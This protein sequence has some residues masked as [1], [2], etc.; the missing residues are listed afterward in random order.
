MI[1][2]ETLKKKLVGTKLEAW[3]PTLGSDVK[4]ALAEKRNGDMHKWR[5]ALNQISN[6]LATPMTLEDGVITIG[7]EVSLPT[8]RRKSLESALR[9]LLPWRKGPFFVHGIHIDTEW[10][11]DF[12]WNRIKNHIHPLEGQTVLDVGCGN[13]YHCWIMALEGA[14]FAIGIDPVVK[15]IMQY[16]AINSF[17]E[18]ATAFVLPLR[19]EQVPRNLC[20]FDTV[21]SMGLLHHRK[22]PL[23]HIMNL[24]DC[25]VPNGQLVLETLVIEG[26]NGQVLV[27]EGRYAKMRNVWFL[28]TPETLASWIRRC[29]FID[30]QIVDVTL[31]TLEEQCSTDWMAEESLFHFLDPRD[32]T[33]TVEG[34]PAPIRATLIGRKK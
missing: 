2:Y 22:S 27:P 30:V 9:I 18:Q 23:E 33:K 19:I 28:P 11:S 34:H 12:K 15:N 31:T 16:L 17:T 8:D 13:G 24:R 21:F 7:N 1:I 10:R 20:G 3:L 25:L 26:A 5:D 14:E 6:V 29:G 32:H 4:R